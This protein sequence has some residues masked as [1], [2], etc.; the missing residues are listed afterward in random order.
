MKFTIIY[1]PVAGGG[2]SAAAWKSVKAEL[3]KRKIEYDFQTTKYQG[4]AEY[5]A[6]RLAEQSRKALSDQT[7]LV[8]G[9]DGTL[10]EALN[11]VLKENDD[12]GQKIPLAY[13]PAGTGNDFA[14]GFGIK[15]RPV[16]ALEQVLSATENTEINVGHYHEDN[17]GE[18]GYFL[19]NIGIGFDASIVSRT[20]ASRGKQALNHAKIG[21]LSY[22]LY[23]FGVLY[24]QQSFRLTVSTADHRQNFPQCFIAIIANHPYIG[25]GFR[26]AP[27]A[28]VAEDALD[29]VVAER[30]GWPRTLWIARLFASGKLINSRFATHYHGKN[31]QYSTTSLAFGQTDGQDMGN[32]YFNL[33]VN[34]AKA[35]FRQSTTIPNSSREK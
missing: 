17:K 2:T 34:T 19:N 11:G 13:I 22:L 5:L 16:E 20:N 4:H 6:R 23:A 30:R 28:S 8:V 31:F 10:H 32:R 3:D 9:G 35:V 27:N 1:N 15:L 21:R 25:G 12:Q 7:L 24:A 29:L 33:H 26:I 18:D 14:R